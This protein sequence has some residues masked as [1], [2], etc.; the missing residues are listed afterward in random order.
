MP[1]FSTRLLSLRYSLATVAEQCA[2]IAARHRVDEG[3]AVGAHALHLH[4]DEQLV[5]AVGGGAA[6]VGCFWFNDGL[7][8]DE[9]ASP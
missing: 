2:R 9:S 8:C 4:F 3:P 5:V 1:Y 7:Q 6:C